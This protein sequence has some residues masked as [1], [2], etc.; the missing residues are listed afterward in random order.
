MVV[1]LPDRGRLRLRCQMHQVVTIPIGVDKKLTGIVKSVNSRKKR[2]IEE[3]KNKSGFFG[4]WVALARETRE[5]RVEGKGQKVGKNREN[6]NY[7]Q[8]III[9][10]IIVMP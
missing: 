5:R 7:A 6:D 4:S 2:P 9:I 10:I 8:N 1:V 3:N